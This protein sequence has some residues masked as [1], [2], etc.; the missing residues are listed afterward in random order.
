MNPTFPQRKRH[1]YPGYDY[2]QPGAYYFTIV[3]HSRDKLFGNIVDGKCEY[4]S[5]GKIV[6]TTWQGLA[7]RY[8]YLLLDESV[9]MPNHFH[10]IL[11]YT[12][13]RTNNGERIVEIIKVKPLGQIIGAFKTTTAKQIN[14]LR[15]TPGASVWQADFYERIIRNDFELDSVRNYIQANPVRWE[16]DLD[17]LENM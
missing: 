6:V 2:S 4:N 14:L 8:P 13:T 17:D 7:E 16:S 12:E 10:G 9:L 11:F 1:R 15:G 5:F 3:S